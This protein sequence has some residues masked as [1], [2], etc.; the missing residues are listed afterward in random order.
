MCLDA[1]GGKRIQKVEP[2]KLMVREKTIKVNI[3]AAGRC[4][5]G[6]RDGR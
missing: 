2:A 1:V 4:I 5:W 3:A 6:G